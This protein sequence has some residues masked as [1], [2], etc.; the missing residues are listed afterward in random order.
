MLD[1]TEHT[2]TRE[3]DAHTILHTAADWLRA[4]GWHRHDRR[5]RQHDL[6]LT[7]YQAALVE[8]GEPLRDYGAPA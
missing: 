1:T 7:M 4:R 8:K 5:W 2:A 6:D 3:H